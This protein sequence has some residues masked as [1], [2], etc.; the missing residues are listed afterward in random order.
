MLLYYSVRKVRQPDS[1]L[2]LWINEGASKETKRRRT[3]RSGCTSKFMRLLIKV[4][5]TLRDG[6]HTY[7]VCGTRVN[8]PI[9][10][11][12]YELHGCLLRTDFFH[13][14]S[15][16]VLLPWAL[17][18]KFPVIGWRCVYTH[19]SLV[20]YVNTDYAHVIEHGM[21]KDTI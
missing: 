19:T 11:V 15:F 14:I 13:K 20:N 7:I 4:R 3:V 2:T 18:R 9:S 6:P 1:S 8:L 16:S 21:G 5:R 10:R 12:S 17:F